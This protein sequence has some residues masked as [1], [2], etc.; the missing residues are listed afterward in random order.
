MKKILSALVA[1]AFLAGSAYAADQAT[2][3]AAKAQADQQ[4]VEDTHKASP[5]KKKA[6]KGAKK[7]AKATEAPKSDMAPAPAMK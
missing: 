5:A 7:S 6:K 2:K 4:R 1:V 3:D